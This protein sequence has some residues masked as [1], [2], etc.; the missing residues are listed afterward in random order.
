[1][2]DLKIDS[3]VNKEN[4]IDI[5]YI[6]RDLV[7][8]DDNKNNFH[9]YLDGKL[10]PFI[11]LKAYPSFKK[12]EYESIKDG[13]HIT[14]D[15]GYRSGEYQKRIFKKYYDEYLKIIM[16]E[17]PNID[18]TMAKRQAYELTVLRVAAPG[19]SEHQTGYAFDAASYRDGVYNAGT[20]DTERAWLNENAYRYGFILR[21][22]K[23]KEEITK[24][25]FEPWH[26][27]FVGKDISRELYNY[28]N[29]VTLEEFHEDN[30]KVR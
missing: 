9:G 17:N 11:S 8:V 30:K 10:K 2:H 28:G 12:M 15:S 29:W 13:I 4:P 6:P 14:V 5:N 24:F 21:Y 7:A 1:M 19:C 27:R 25:G 26:Y 16:D 22:P 3:L 18:E 23:G 20:N